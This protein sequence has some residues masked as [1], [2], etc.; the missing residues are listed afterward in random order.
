MLKKNN[1]R[2][3]P[4]LLNILGFKLT[5]RGRTYE[6][7]DSLNMHLYLYI[8]NLVVYKNNEVQFYRLNEV[9]EFITYIKSND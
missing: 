4:T 3:T 1:L 6:Y 8:K 2:I 9:K 5:R 7:Y